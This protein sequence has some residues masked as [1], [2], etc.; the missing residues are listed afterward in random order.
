MN[1]KIV[2]IIISFIIVI[3]CISFKAFACKIDTQEENHFQ[4]ILFKNKKSYQGKNMDVFSSIIASCSGKT[5][6]YGVTVQFDTFD[7]RQEIA[8]HIFNKFNVNNKLEKQTS[9]NDE[10]YSIKFHGNSMDGYI[11]SIKYDDH[12][13]VK[14]DIIKH[15]K[16]YL[17]RQFNS[18]VHSRMK[19]F[20]NDIRYFQYVKVKTEDKDIKKTYDKCAG[21][22]RKIGTAYINTDALENGYTSTAYTGRYESI[23]SGGEDI[24]FNFAVVKYSTGI[25][26]VMGTPEIME[27]Y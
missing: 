15:D 26:V 4:N 27:T 13:I 11:E 25:Y 24:D 6:E 7:S 22:L 14:V 23:K 1:K 17:L 5:V 12:N 20:S 3:T 21:T 18:Y 10:S 2:C 16:K 8:N 9:L 19:D